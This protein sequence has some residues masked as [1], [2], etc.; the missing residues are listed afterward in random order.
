MS[1]PKWTGMGASIEGTLYFDN[2]R[3]ERHVTNLTRPGTLRETNTFIENNSIRGANSAVKEINVFLGGVSGSTV[4]YHPVV[5][6]N[7]SA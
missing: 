3:N 6:R 1:V 5:A 7:A 4:Q 2:R